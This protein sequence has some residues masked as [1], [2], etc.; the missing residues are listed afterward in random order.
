MSL[1]PIRFSVN[2][3]GCDKKWE[4]E[5]LASRYQDKTGTLQDFVHHIKQGHA[6]CAGQLGGQ[7][8]TKATVIGSQMTM[9]DVDNS[10]PLLGVDGKAVKGEDG[11]SIKVYDPRL[12]LDQALAHPFIQQYCAL[13]YTSASHKPDWHKFRLVFL[14]PQYETDTGII[15][16]MI[17]Q[18]MEQLPHDPACKDASRVFYGNTRAEIPLFNPHVTLPTEWRE[19]AIFSAAEESSKKEQ[20]QKQREFKQAEYQRQIQRGEVSREDTD[21]LILDALRFIP[22]RDPGSGNYQ[23]CLTVLMALYDHFGEG[24]AE[25][26]AERWSPSIK[27]T[28]WDI[29]R[30]LRT[31]KRGGV[32]IGS[33]FHIAKQHGW[34]F[35]E[36]ERTEWQKS[37]PTISAEEWQYKFGLPN[38]FRS[39][40]AK[41]PKIFKGFGKPPKTFE[42]KPL[43]KTIKYIP[44][45]LP[46]PEQ[47]KGLGCPIV[48]FAPGQR[49]QLL[50]KLVELGY[51]DILSRTLN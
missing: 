20:Q 35:P 43:P 27:G 37:E 24:E 15:E 6:V 44:G 47:Y 31:F 7:R 12:T 26:V 32:G 4:Y 25:R 11:K 23:E 8:R 46:S 50:A 9:L 18:L 38:W 39:Q 40:L 13:I 51:H 34:K 28:T 30:K 33:L 21:A 2:T 5:L 14:L 1:T 17:R 19:Q 22:P 10:A 36:R 29:G 41:L 48:R 45:E 16:A 3:H 49:L 42:P